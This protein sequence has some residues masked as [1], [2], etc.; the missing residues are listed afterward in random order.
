MS[1]PVMSIRDQMSHVYDESKTIHALP[2]DIL[3]TVFH[4]ATESEPHFSI[5]LSHCCLR[6][7]HFA[8]NTPSLW[9]TISFVKPREY[10]HRKGGAP[11]QNASPDFAKQRA[12]LARSQDLLIDVIIGLEWPIFKQS[13][14]YRFFI[15]F[16]PRALSHIMKIILPHIDRWKVFKVHSI[17]HKGCRTIF[18]R[19]ITLHAPNLET[20]DAEIPR[21]YGN[22][23]RFRPFKQGQGVP[24]LRNLRVGF[25]VG[26]NQWTGSLFSSLTTLTLSHVDDEYHPNS[27]TIIPLLSRNIGLQSLTL[28]I[29]LYS[30]DETHFD[31]LHPTLLTLP[32]LHTICLGSDE[33]KPY[34]DLRR[35]MAVLLLSLDL[36][37]LTTLVPSTFADRSLQI[38]IAMPSLSF[39]KL[40]DICIMSPDCTKDIYNTLIQLQSLHSLTIA[41]YFQQSDLYD[42]STD[43]IQPLCTMFPDLRK[44]GLIKYS[45][46][47]IPGNVTLSP[48]DIFRRI[49][50]ARSTASDLSNIESFNVG[51]GQVSEEDLVWLKDKNVNFISRDIPEF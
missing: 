4:L 14:N 40:Q 26:M 22:R 34:T 10:M 31:P 12:Y 32:F 17:T 9:T 2:L 28:N 41:S 36:P 29:T 45:T 35:E 25:G 50:T 24:R 19:L 49:Y 6:W 13:R 8:I 51:Y 15:S 46:D 30:F 27:N 33:D 37:A 42:W 3:Y 21:G 20:L 11:A 16:S 44:L 18:D 1:Q 39:K 7:R 38:L 47:D 5:V 48:T 43:V 23:W